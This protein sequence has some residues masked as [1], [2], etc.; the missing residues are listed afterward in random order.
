MQLP[1]ISLPTFTIDIPPRKVGG[2]G[3]PFRPMLVKEE[4]LLLMAKQNE[5]PTSILGAIKQVVNNCCLDPTFQVDII[6]LFALEYVFIKLRA[7]S[8]GDEIDVSYKDFEDKKTYPFTIDLKK[9]EV[10][11]PDPLPDSKIA[12][13]PHSGI[14]LKYPPASLYDDKNFLANEGEDAFYA[15]I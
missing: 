13:T 12:I 9:V 4:K 6:P 10:K 2:K 8:V 15:L 1:K 11:Y 7:A 3:T 14:V 5:D